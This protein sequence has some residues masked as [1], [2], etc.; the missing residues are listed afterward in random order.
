MSAGFPDRLLDRGDGADQVRGGQGNDSLFGGSGND[1]VSG[2]RGEDAASGGTGAA[3]FHGRPDAGIDRLLDFHAAEGDRAM[4]DP[5][6]IFAV[7]QLGAD[8]R[9]DRGGGAEMTL[10]G[11]QLSTLPAG[12]KFLARPKSDLRRAYWAK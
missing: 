10:V 9:L 11:V 3:I 2:D 1:F 4:L 7:R 12:T 6:A 8:T 5:G